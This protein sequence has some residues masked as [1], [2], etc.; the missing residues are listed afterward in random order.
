MN[1]AERDDERFGTAIEE[2]YFRRVVGDGMRLPQEL[3]PA[4]I[5]DHAGAR[6]IDIQPVGL[7]GCAAVEA[8]PEMER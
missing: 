2:R 5:D 7:A 6:C 4:G 3:V 8:H 1:S